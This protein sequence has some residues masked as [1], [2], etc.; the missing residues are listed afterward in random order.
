[1]I[2]LIDCDGILADFI[3]GVCKLLHAKSGVLY[4]SN[5]VTEWDFCRSLEID[6]TQTYRWISEATN[7]ASCLYPYPG[8][9]IGMAKLCAVG[10]V[11]VVTS[12]WSSNPTWMNDRERWLLRW[13]GIRPERIIQCKDKFL[14]SGD[15]YIDDRTQNC[16]DWRAY[17]AGVVIRWDNLHNRNDVWD[18]KHTNDWD[19][20]RRIV[21]GI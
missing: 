14:I 2:V 4:K 9:I 17:H 13:Y 11:Y 12:P 7:F 1:V 10:E 18:G 21:H 20:L 15:V 3:G 16:L 5:Q 6:R 19:E 8:S